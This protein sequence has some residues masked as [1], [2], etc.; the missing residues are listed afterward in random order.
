[1]LKQGSCIQSVRRWRHL[2]CLPLP[3]Q[4][5]SL[6]KRDRRQQSATA[7]SLDIIGTTAHDKVCKSNCNTANC[8]QWWETTFNNTD[9]NNL[10]PWTNLVLLFML[11]TA[12]TSNVA[13][14]RQLMDYLQRIN[15][16]EFDPC[17]LLITLVWTQNP[18]LQPL[19][20]KKFCTLATSAPVERV[21]SHSGFIMRPHRAKMNDGLLKTLV[22][23]KCNLVW[24]SLFKNKTT[25]V[26]R[27]LRYRHIHIIH[28]F[29]II[30]CILCILSFTYCVY[31]CICLCCHLA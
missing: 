8:I 22:M 23:L 26:L 25:E 14:E 21:F 29:I 5:V 12:T 9:S 4:R 16:L 13:P 15:S 17:D 19:F 20:A 28:I 3:H 30:E 6:Q 18:L 10:T 27:H 7:A 11:L 24:L 31:N 1:M 2:S